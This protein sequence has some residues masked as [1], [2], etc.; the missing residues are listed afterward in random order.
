M[1]AKPSLQLAR[2][3]TQCLPIELPLQTMFARVS[4]LENSF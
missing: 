2:F 4:E 1:E 3:L